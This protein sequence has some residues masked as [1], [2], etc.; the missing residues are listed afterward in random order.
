MA[1]Q[2]ND[3]I[4]IW[5]S[6]FFSPCRRFASKAQM[7]HQVLDS[8]VTAHTRDQIFPGRV[9]S[10]PTRPGKVVD[11]IIM[12]GC[13]SIMPRHAGWIM[14][15]TDFHFYTFE[16]VDCTTVLIKT[17]PSLISGIEIVFLI[18]FRIRILFIL[19]DILIDQK[20]FRN[21]LL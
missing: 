18:C 9:R 15:P 5:S 10:L 1:F 12:C 7:R 16:P 3:V 2:S 19:E 4:E 21:I 8:E 20:L 14:W 17:L 11:L 13:Q 6:N